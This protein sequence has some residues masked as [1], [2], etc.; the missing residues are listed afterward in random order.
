[1]NNYQ[2]KVKEAREEFLKVMANQEKELVKIYAEASKIIEEKLKRAPS[3]GITERY[4]KALKLS[5]DSYIKELRIELKQSI[6]ESINKV[7]DIATGIQINFFD[8]VA[9]TLK[10]KQ[11]FKS[12]FTQISK[13]T[14][15]RMLAGKYYSDGKTLDDRLWLLTAKN[16]KDIERLITLNMASGTN[17]RE[18]AKLLDRYINPNKILIKRNMA[19]KIDKHI[20]YQ[21]ARLARTS[22]THTY[23]ETLIENTMKNPFA[24][25]LKWNTSSAHYERQIKKYG[26][27]MCTWNNGKV[28]K[29]KTIPLQHPNCLCYF[30]VETIP[31]EEARKELVA[32]VNGKEDKALDNWLNKYGKEYGIEV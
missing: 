32:W 20:S 5:V 4:L 8:Q 13:D 1:M 3:G 15:K 17:A 2:K 19:D 18:L 23:S 9:P 27:D 12:M 30:T 24:T 16:A 11:S 28:F 10:L 21:A 31:V 29:P 22:L 25:G 6:E 7:G 26:E 14:V